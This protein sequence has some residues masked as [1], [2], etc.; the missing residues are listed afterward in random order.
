MHPCKTRKKKYTHT[1]LGLD[2]SGAGCD[3]V[4]RETHDLHLFGCS[5]VVVHTLESALR[6]MLT[7]GHTDGRRDGGRDEWMDKGQEG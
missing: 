4:Q 7:D 5:H 2:G 1:L 3:L 6:D